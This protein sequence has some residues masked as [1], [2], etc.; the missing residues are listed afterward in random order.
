MQPEAENFV[1]WEAESVFDEGDFLI[2]FLLLKHPFFCWLPLKNVDNR[3]VHLPAFLC[4]FS[5]QRGRKQR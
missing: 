2:F 3:N 5:S 1:G 4:Y